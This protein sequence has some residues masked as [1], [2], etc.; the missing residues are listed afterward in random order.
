MFRRGSIVKIR[1][2][3]NGIFDLKPEFSLVLFEFAARGSKQV[4]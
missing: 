1:P 3:L 2:R 4:A